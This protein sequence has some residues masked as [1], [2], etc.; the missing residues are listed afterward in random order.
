MSDTIKVR[1]AVAVAPS[2][3]WHAAGGGIIGETA[4]ERE[5]RDADNMN[6]ASEIWEGNN[7]CADGEARYWVTVELPIPAPIEV[8]GKVEP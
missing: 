3:S 4:S 7:E 6:F 8:I 1:I 5:A 2:G